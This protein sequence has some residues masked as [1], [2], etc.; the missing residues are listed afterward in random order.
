MIK[1]VAIIV[2]YNPDFSTLKILV[3]SIYNQ[4]DKIYIVDNCSFNQFD[5]FTDKK[6]CIINLP[7]NKGIATAQNI[8]FTQA[9]EDGFNDFILFDQ[10][11]QPSENMIEKLMVAR[12]SAQYSGVE[13]AAV[14][15]LHIDQDD[16]RECV[17]VDTSKGKVEKVIPRSIKLTSNNWF[18]CDF[19]IASGCLISKQSLDVVGLM[20]G[21]LFIDC[22]DIEWCYRAMSKGLHCVA[23]LDA[24]MYHKI[25]DKPL[26]IL[27]R[28]LT[29]HSPIRHYYFYRNFY[30]LLKRGYIPFCWKKHV[31]VKSTIQAIV[32]SI[33]LYPRLEQIKF[34]VIGFFHGLIGRLGKYE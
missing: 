8:G 14:G 22:V 21:D 34:I 1:P 12:Q 32:F 7:E 5:I 29:T 23:A 2:T 11:S 19:I 3:G 13:V 15:P 18:C 33:F 30:S 16:F 31:L 4:V 6:V 9:I 10:D 25:G 24:K 17:Y 26:T 28:R 27:G 20:E